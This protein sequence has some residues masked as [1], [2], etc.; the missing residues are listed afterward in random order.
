MRAILGLR[1]VAVHHAQH[2][3]VVSGQ[4]Q[5]IGNVLR[6]SRVAVHDR[7][8]AFRRNHRIHGVLLHQDPIG[9]TKG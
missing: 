9:N 5:R 1:H 3:A 2:Q 6:P 8:C 4:L 7:G